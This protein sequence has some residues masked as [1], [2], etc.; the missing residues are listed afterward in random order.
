M[1]RRTKVFRALA[2][3]RI[4]RILARQRSSLISK[5]I[6]VSFSDTLEFTRVS[7]S[8]TSLGLLGHTLAQEIERRGDALGIHRADRLDGRLDRLSGYEARGE[9]AGEGVFADEVEDLRLLGEP[10]KAFAHRKRL[11]G[12]GNDW[13]RST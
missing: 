8:R 5:P 9:F 12:V 11:W 4:V 6:W 2:L 13:A 7:A 3:S 1:S 10:E